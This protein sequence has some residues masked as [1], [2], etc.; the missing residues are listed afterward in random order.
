ML[1][2]EQLKWDSLHLKD[3]LL[4]G[5]YSYG[6]EN[7]SPIQLK[8]IT[9]FLSGI[10]M[11]AQA[12]SGTG[13]TGAYT[14]SVLQKIDLTYMGTQAIILAPTHE[15][16]CQIANV[17][18]KLG[19]FMSNLKIQTLVGGTSVHSDIQ[20][21]IKDNPHVIIGSPGRVYDILQRNIIN[22]KKI[23]VIVLDE[24]DELLS[25]GFRENIRY[26]LK[27]VEINTQCVFFSAT[28]PEHILDLSKQ[29]MNNPLYL[30]LKPE[31]LNVD[32]IQHYFIKIYNDDEKYDMIKILFSSCSMSQCIIY[33]NNVDDV[34]KLH[35]NMTSDNYPVSCIHSS[36]TKEERIRSF[37]EFENGSSRMLI[38]SNIT[39]RGIDI[40]QVGMV[41]NYDIPYNV[42]TYL[43][44]VGRGGRYGRKGVAINL[45]SKYDINKLQNIENHYKITIDEYKLC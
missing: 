10:D 18:R 31:E 40:Q 26:I 32:G 12:K 19:G 35:R 7:P 16:V 27:M 11:V 25:P 3:D 23:N 21:I 17:M 30:T 4:R 2:P 43:H 44:R 45:V 33:V 37:H 22:I 1:Q 20:S 9:P 5:I 8:A 39:A 13:K 15:L 28:L 38:S 29:I 6:F 14:I 41:I 24:A 36:M 34:I 42:C